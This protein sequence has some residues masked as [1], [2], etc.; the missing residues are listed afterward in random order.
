MTKKE[1]ED[2]YREFILP[3]VKV[4]Y[5]RDGKIDAPARAEAWNEYTDG[6]CKGGLITLKQYE[7]WRHP[8]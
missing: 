1:A 8:R 6:L 3:A 5:E 4:A 7:S 2:H